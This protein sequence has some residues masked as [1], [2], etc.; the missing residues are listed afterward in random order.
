MRSES[1]LR[2]MQKHLSERAYA[3]TL[4]RDQCVRIRDHHGV[5]D[6]SSDLRELEAVDDALEWVLGERETL[7]Y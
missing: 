3:L 2:A 1:E 6:A 4:Y 7:G 5:Q